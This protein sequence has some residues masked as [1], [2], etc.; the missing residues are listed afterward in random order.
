M[1]RLLCVIGTCACLAAGVV[2]AY[3]AAQWR[4]SDPESVRLQSQ[5]S[6]VEVFRQ[7]EF[8]RAEACEQAI[9]PLMAQAQVLA[10]ILNPPV[11]AVAR[12][13]ESASVPGPLARTPSTSLRAGSSASPRFRVVAVSCYPQ[14]PERSMALIEPTIGGEAKW[15]KEGTPV[16]HFVVHEIRQGLV[17]LRN[18]E[19]RCELTV[20]RNHVERSLVRD[21][22]PGSRQV[23][24][25]GLDGTLMPETR[26]ETDR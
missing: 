4:Q 16:G 11:V 26:S 8:Q 1:V 17:V 3:S 25:A 13:A 15:A 12:E 18:G 7:Q 5:L 22:R 6:V 21:V 14:R 9:S 19:Q 10:D 24:A 23:S 2:F 20:E